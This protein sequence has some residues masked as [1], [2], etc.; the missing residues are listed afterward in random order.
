MTKCQLSSCCSNFK[1]AQSIV[2]SLSAQALLLDENKRGFC[3]GTILNEYIILTA[4]HCMNQTSYFSVKLGNSQQLLSSQKKQRQFI[5][6]FFQS[7]TIA[8]L[9]GD[10]PPFAFRGV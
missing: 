9:K 4:A 3:G 10:S 7:L 2:A 5:V 1:D 8:L 6:L